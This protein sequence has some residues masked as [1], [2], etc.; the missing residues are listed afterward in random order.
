MSCNALLSNL[1]VPQ[2]GS[3]H[4]SGTGTNSEATIVSAGSNTNGVM[5]VVA[6][7]YAQAT[8]SGQPTA[9]AYVKAGSDVIIRAQAPWKNEYSASAVAAGPFIVPAGNALIGFGT[10]G[11]CG[12]DISYEIL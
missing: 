12:Y 1:T 11:N 6:N 2:L 4:V 9:Q 7:V 5:V 3:N 10:A 8:T